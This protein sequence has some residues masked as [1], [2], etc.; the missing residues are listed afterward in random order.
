VPEGM[1]LKP[2]W[3][4]AKLVSQGKATNSL[5]LGPAAFSPSKKFH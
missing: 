2:D 1:A 4:F 3:L 5:I